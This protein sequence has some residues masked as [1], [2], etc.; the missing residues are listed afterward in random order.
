MHHIIMVACGVAV[1]FSFAIIFF[2]IDTWREEV[3]DR[4][5]RDR[6]ALAAMVN[7]SLYSPQLQFRTALWHG[8]DI[9][10][11][12]GL[13]RIE[14]VKYIQVLEEDGTVD[15]SSL[16]QDRTPHEG[17]L[18]NAKKVISTDRTQVM[19]DTLEE[20]R[21]KK[22]IY[23]GYGNNAVVVATSIEDLLEEVRVWAWT[24]YTLGFLVLAGV[25]I[26]FFF[27]LY[28]A[29]IVPIRRVS[30]EHEK[31]G[32][33]EMESAILEDRGPKEI[34]DIATSFN[35]MVSKLKS[36][37]E[38]AEEQ[39]KVLEV[40][41]DARTKELKEL[42]KKLERQVKERTKE[43]ERQVEEYEKANKLMVGRELKMMELKKQLKKAKKIIKK[44]KEE[45]N[46]KKE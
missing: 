41:V 9:V 4:R 35:Q 38:E 2:G 29:V 22:V 40:R 30:R 46:G 33:G 28:K 17:L 25:F 6:E 39:K 44:L 19:D 26:S 5:V 23:P 42:N 14:D 7:E 27:F 15:V 12:D 24:G 20:E 45:K 3:I 31:V 11:L 36:Y 43:L 37:Q 16:D 18:K 34:R 32:R 10:L 8:L 1:L 13:A 21:V